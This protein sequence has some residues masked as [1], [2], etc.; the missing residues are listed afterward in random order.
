MS[1]TGPEMD[2]AGVLETPETTGL[3]AVFG[4]FHAAGLLRS[5]DFDAFRGAVRRAAEAG[6]GPVDT[7]D[8]L[9]NETILTCA[10]REHTTAV[11]NGVPAASFSRLGKR[12]AS[13]AAAATA[14]AGAAGDGRPAQRQRTINGGAS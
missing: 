14:G 7:A 5:A 13:A 11:D 6:D 10:V 8:M 2:P 1:H 3:L 4:A 9:L 12:P